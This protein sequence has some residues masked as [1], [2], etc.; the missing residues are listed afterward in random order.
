MDRPGSRR[1]L[2]LGLDGVPWELLQALMTRGQ[3]PVFS[4]LL[5]E[6]I[7]GTLRSTLPPITGPAWTSFATGVN[8]GK[9]GIFGF[10]Q[11]GPGFEPRVVGPQDIKAET[12]PEILTK[13]GLRS[14]FINLPASSP[15]PGFGGIM[16]ADLLSP[17]PYIYPENLSAYLD[18]Y[19]IFHELSID[20]EARVADIIDLERRRLTLARRLVAEQPW[21]FFFCLVSGTDWVMHLCYDELLRG[22]PLGNRALELFGLVDQFL[23]W[24]LDHLP[25]DMSL[26]MLS[27]HGFQSSNRVLDINGWLRSRGYAARRRRPEDHSGHL[28][29]KG[30][31]PWERAR[32]PL[33]AVDLVEKYPRVK[34]LGLGLLRRVAGDEFR[35]SSPYTVDVAK[36]RAFA[37]TPTPYEIYVNRNLV[38]DEGEYRQLVDEIIEGLRELQDPFTAEPAFDLVVRRDEAY[39]GPYTAAAPDILCLPRPGLLLDKT[40][41]NEGRFVAREANYH[42][43]EGFLLIRGGGTGPSRDVG[44]VR[45]WDMTPTVLRLLGAAIPGGMDGRPL[46]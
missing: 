45:L 2:V 3:L 23:G 18:G 27:D 1:V 38:Q 41:L 25:E 34:G 33:W 42:S 35:F 5:Q 36:S 16:V 10:V 44:E 7:R 43:M 46:V 40:F 37:I 31:P 12:L 30:A 21:D 39:S 24:V 11:Y 14:I 9:H 13:Q 26:V 29:R 4:S 15:P 32:L 20:G 8:P 6:G 19:R 28:V 22:G 17:R